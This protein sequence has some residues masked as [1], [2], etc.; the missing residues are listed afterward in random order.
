VGYWSE[1]G[2]WR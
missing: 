2:Q 1:E